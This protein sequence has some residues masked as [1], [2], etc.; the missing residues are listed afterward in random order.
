[1]RIEVMEEE[2][3]PAVTEIESASFRSPWP[4]GAFLEEIRST[5]FARCFVARGGAGAKEAGTEGYVCFWLLGHELLI[6]NL[7]VAPGRRRRGIGRCLLLHALGEGRRAGCSVAYLEVRESN[8]A[9]ILLY[10]G[11]G[12]KVVGRRRGY[13]SD[14]NEDA[15]LM[16]ADLT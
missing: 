15:L 16:R 13:Y 3:L 6:N 2:D 5:N 10:Q 8:D 11:E 4:P 12:F 1:M 7:A 9:A 14:T